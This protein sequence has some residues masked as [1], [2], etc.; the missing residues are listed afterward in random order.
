M[1]FS[2]PE[3]I[4][5]FLPLVLLITL[6]SGKKLSNYIL[7]LASL[8][9][10]TWGEGGLV[11]LM[12]ISMLVNYLFGLW[13]GS[14]KTDKSSKIV[15]TTAIVFNIGLLVAF[16]YTNFFIDNINVLI[17][18]FGM[19]R[20]NIKPIHL[21]IGISFY[22]F[23]ALSYLIDI[24]RKDSAAQKNPFNIA[25]YISLFPQLIAGPIVKYHDISQQLINRTLSIDKFASGVKRFIMGLGKKVLIANTL[26]TVADHVFAI[27]PGEMNTSVAWL[28]IVAYTLQIYFDFSGYSDM[29]IGLARML[30][31]EF[32]E[33]FN[34]PYIATS[35]KEFWRRWHISL[36][37]WFAEYLF[38]PLSLQF[39]AWRIKGLVLAILINFLLIG[40]WHGA[41]WSFIFWGLFH[42][43]FLVLEQLGWQR[44]LD[45]I[46][47][48]FSHIYTLLVV[49]FS[50]VFFRADNIDHAFIYLKSL[51]GFTHH[52]QTAYYST[53][54]YL[55]REVLL[56]FLIGILFSTPLYNRLQHLFENWL[57][58]HPD[59]LMKPIKSAFSLVSLVFYFS[60]FFASTM[61]LASGT[62]NPFIYFRF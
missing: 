53:D 27:P 17:E 44:I 48:P 51:L 39:R 20:I 59:K 8:L 28:G 5:L 41:S 31:F 34:Y 23:H 60:I 11:I 16:K 21:P 7:I 38:K 13:L 42:G 4:F 35:I 54:M 26:A 12:I 9:F 62:Y 24:Y 3:F 43:F 1:V 52:L 6:L 32:L 19:T 18:S 37:T 29:A 10:Y 56:T 36:S 50:W 61:S 2:S 14:A 57:T 45:K 30:G 22:T 49:V 46:W 33:N 47:K 15:M 58:T 25:L 40:F 55:N